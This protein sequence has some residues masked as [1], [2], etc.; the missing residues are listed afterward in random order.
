VNRPVTFLLL[1]LAVLACRRAPE[2]PPAQPAQQKQPAEQKQPVESDSVPIS[3]P[4]TDIDGDNLLNLAYGAAL[5]SRT[6]ESNLE[7]SAVHAIDGMSFTAWMSSPGDPAQTLVYALGAPSRVEELGVTTTHRNQSPEKVG[8]SA[9]SD[10]RSW[11]EITT[12]Q[13]LNRGTKTAPVPPFETRYLRVETIEPK[14]NYT[15]LVSVHAFGRELG[16]AERHSF[17]GCWTVNTRR[18]T[19]IQRGARITGMI[20]GPREPTYVDGGME[21]RVAKLTWMRGPMWGYAVATLT[22]DGSGLSG[23]TFHEDPLI[24]QVG[25]GWIGTRCDS[26]VT[27]TLPA[28]ADYLRRMRR[29]M[30]AGVLFDGNEQL[31]EEPSGPTL[32]TA[33]AL[34]RNAPAQRF[35]VIA[36][37]FRNNDPNENLRRTAARIDAIRTAL[38]TRGVDVERMEF[39]ADGSKRT[40]VEM[41]SAI[42][43]ML[44]SRIDLEPLQ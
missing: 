21:G 20:E 26:P 14:E 44:G 36:R 3:Q 38:R 4:V 29:W 5:V 40:G 1:L 11:R 19:F 23:I 17:N 28:P 22:P 30:M 27:L 18:A 39:V 33:A 16:P 24:N 37:E 10:G 6:G 34:I 7:A 35:R 15:T 41:P 2:P 9:S 42:Q 25:V 43:R 8:F 12:V 13:P 32:D 31:L